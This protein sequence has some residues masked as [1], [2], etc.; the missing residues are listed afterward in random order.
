M[1]PSADGYALGSI[2]GRVAVQCVSFF[3]SSPAGTMYE[4]VAYVFWAT[5]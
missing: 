2:E 4:P 3:V 5:S 1:F